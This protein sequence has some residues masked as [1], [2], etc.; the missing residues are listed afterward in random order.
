MLS[1]N[2]CLSVCPSVCPFV[3]LSVTRRYSVE[4]AKHIIKLILPTG[5]YTILVK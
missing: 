2:V 5:S 1:Q 4:T 3:C